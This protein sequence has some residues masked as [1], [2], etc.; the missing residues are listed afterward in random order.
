MPFFAGVQQSQDED[1]AHRVVF[2]KGLHQLDG[3]NY[4]ADLRTIFSQYG[5]VTQVLVRR[6]IRKVGTDYGSWGLVTFADAS[7]ASKAVEAPVEVQTKAVRTAPS[8]HHHTHTKPLLQTG[9]FRLLV[10]PNFL[11]AAEI[12][13]TMQYST[14]YE[15]FLTIGLFC[16]NG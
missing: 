14:T 2:I 10:A 3:F 12:S 13:C 1:Y 16:L 5:T 15:S 9:V 11:F 6:R 8:P 4:D 7:M